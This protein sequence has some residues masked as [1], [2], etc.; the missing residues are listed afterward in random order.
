[1]ADR[2]FEIAKD[3]KVLYVEDDKDSREKIKEVLEVFFKEVDTA[4][5]GEE[6]LEKFKKNKYDVVFADIYMPKMDGLE[7]VKK[8]KEI[9]PN[10]KCIMITAYSDSYFLLEA[11][12]SQVDGFLLKPINLEALKKVLKKIL[13]GIYTYKMMEQYNEIIVNELEKQTQALALKYIKDDVTGLHNR[14]ALDEILKNDEENKS[15][16]LIDIHDFGVINL[17]YGYH[18]GDKLLN[19]FAKFLK[20][21]I[22]EDD[23]FRIEADKFAIITYKNREEILQLIHHILHQLE[24]KECFIIDGDKIY[25]DV[26][27]AVAYRTK[28]LLK[29]ARLALEEIKLHKKGNVNFYDSDLEVEKFKRKIIEIKPKII[30]A[31]KDDLIVPVFQPIINNQTLEIERFEALARI[32]DNKGFLMPSDFI[33]IAEHLNLIN[34]ITKVMIQKVFLKAKET[35]HSFTINLSEEDLKENYFVDFVEFK[36]REH[37]I[38]PSQITFEVL[39]YISSDEIEQSIYK[40][41]RLKDLGFRLSLDDFGTNKSNFEKIL[42]LNLDCI[43]IDG[44]FIKNI[45]QNQKS[46]KIVQTIKSL[47][48][49]MNVKTVAEF[50]EDEEIFKAVKELGI[51]YSQGYYFSKPKEDLSEFEKGVKNG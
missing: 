35:G 37:K 27:I 34:D 14:H 19:E 43:K 17:V 3:L 50:V 6:G 51:D 8:I 1:M 11:I 7:M 13:E 45:A 5:D 28:D 23:I 32:R 21:I 29:K 48:E 2:L 24:R 4:A 30:K 44:K 31:L 47:A 46:Y 39:E 18:K 20:T 26:N 49:S 41:M 15:L 12:N 38:D 40:L 42:I 33:P 10:V 16:I 36:L 22:K 25:F 9:D